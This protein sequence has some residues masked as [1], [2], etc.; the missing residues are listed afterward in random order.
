MLN[1]HTLPQVQSHEVSLL[2]VKGVVP[3]LVGIQKLQL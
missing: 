3:L 1:R 2:L